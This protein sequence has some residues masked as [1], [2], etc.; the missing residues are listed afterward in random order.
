M[1]LL[2]QGR[3]VMGL[4]WARKR[5]MGAA[6]SARKR[7][8]GFKRGMMGGAVWTRLRDQKLKAIRQKVKS[9]V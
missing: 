1:L 7:V 4:D 3:R 6:D 2:G 9:T 5:K 8:G